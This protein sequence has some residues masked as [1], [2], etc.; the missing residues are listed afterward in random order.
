MVEGAEDNLESRRYDFLCNKYCS[1][2]FLEEERGT[3]DGDGLFHHDV[4]IGERRAA[5]TIDGS[6]T[7]NLI[8]IEVVEKL[9]LPTC[10][11]T[12]TYLLHSSY[13]TLLISHTA[14]IPITIGV[15]TEVV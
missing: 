10:A 3:F 9:Q 7:L 4:V 15:H 11:R 6:S 8:S 12:V 13:G 14:D 5:A 2:T 1:A